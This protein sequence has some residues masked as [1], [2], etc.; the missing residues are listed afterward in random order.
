MAEVYWIRLAE[1][2]DVFTQ[3]YV[4]VTSKTSSER[5][6]YHV[7]LSNRARV[8]QSKSVVHKEM[9]R[10][11]DKIILETLVICE[12]SYAY[13]LESKLRP[14]QN[15][16]WNVAQGGWGFQSRKYLKH[17]EETRQKMSKSHTGKSINP[18]VVAKRVS[19]ILSKGPWN[20]LDAGKE[21]WRN[22]DVYY[23]DYLLGLTYSFSAK[24]HNLDRGKISSMFRWFSRGWNPLL[25]ENWVSWKANSDQITPNSENK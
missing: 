4:G 14:S 9:N 23:Y 12:D 18:D 19:T 7:M 16:G 6:K 5:F 1:H 17:S 10:W 15:I 8:G 21:N 11:R 3:G 25:D 20:R 22:A 24:K 2:T 13:E